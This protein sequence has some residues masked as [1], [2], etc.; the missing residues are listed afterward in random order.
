L[1]ILIKNIFGVD[2]DMQAVEIARLNLLLRSL[3]KRET[4]PSLTDNIRQGNSLI[5]GTEEELRGYFGDNWREKK[6]FNWEQEFKDIVANSGF[7]VVIGNPPYVRTQTLDKSEVDYFKQCYGSATG[8]YD[9]YIL[10]LERAL[11]LLRH[12]GR[13]GLIL[14][15][16]FFQ[17]EYGRGIRNIISQEGMLEH[18]VNFGPQQIFEE[19]TTYTC[20]LFLKKEKMH[21]FKYAFVKRLYSPAEQLAK[22][23]SQ[24][25]YNSADLMVDSVEAPPPSEQPWLF[26]VSATAGIVGKLLENSV[27]LRDMANHIFVG[28]QT[29]ADKVFILTGPERSCQ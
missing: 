24:E 22:I 26:T 3:A 2:L 18:V 17:T 16:K 25:K 14:P 15:S 9:I 7:D 29:D 8:H 6:P 23:S 1:P 5:S 4:L 27:A 28:P 12:G 13:L 21:R 19:S 20:L 11:S 10:F